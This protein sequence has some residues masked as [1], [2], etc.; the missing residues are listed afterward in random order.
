MPDTFVFD[1]H[2]RLVYRGQLDAA[3]PG[4]NLPVTA[5]DVRS[6]VD[7]ELAGTPS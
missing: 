3:R 7:A 5:A 1:S 2:R 6:A 4:N